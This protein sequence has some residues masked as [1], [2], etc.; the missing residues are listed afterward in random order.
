GV[1]NVDVNGHILVSSVKERI[2]NVV[3]ADGLVPSNNIKFVSGFGWE[4]Y[5]SYNSFV[6]SDDNR[7][8]VFPTLEQAANYDPATTHD[9]ARIY[10][11]ENVK[12]TADVTLRA[13]LFSWVHHLQYV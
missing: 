4:V 2:R 3:S 7:F 8:R 9:V 10:A 6:A 1:V 11:Y 5:S 13:L 12:Q